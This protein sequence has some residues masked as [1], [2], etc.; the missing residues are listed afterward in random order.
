MCASKFVYFQRIRAIVKVY[1][2]ACAH[3]IL[4][5][6][7]WRMWWTWCFDFYCECLS[8][9]FLTHRKDCYCMHNEGSRQLLE[10]IFQGIIGV[11]SL[12]SDLLFWQ[13]CYRWHWK[14]HPFTFIIITGYVLI[15]SDVLWACNS[16]FL[17]FSFWL[18]WSWSRWMFPFFMGI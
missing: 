7:V 5:D 10:N 13:K 4:K 6:K 2:F 9:R 3:F 12:H 1:R 11:S 17:R 14:L 18:W 15:L 8:R 16:C